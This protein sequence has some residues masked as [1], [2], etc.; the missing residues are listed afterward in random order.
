MIRSHT[1]ANFD[2]ADGLP[3]A[4]A[5]SVSTPSATVLPRPISS[6]PNIADSGRISFGAGFRLSS[7]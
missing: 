6:Q 1:V 2:D 4:T 5:D 7:K 3:M